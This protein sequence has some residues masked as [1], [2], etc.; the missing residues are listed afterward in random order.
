VAFQE[1][2]VYDIHRA[3]C[4][5]TLHFRNQ[6]S[7]NDWVWVQAGSEDMDGVLRGRLPAKLV[8]LFKIRDY[9]WE[10]AGRWVAAVWMLSA[11]NSGFP[12]D[13][14]GLVTGQMRE[15]ARE[16]TIVEVGTIDG[17]A[18]LIPEGERRWLVNSRIDLRTFNE[19][20]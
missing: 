17:L 20:Y 2:D 19:V 15:D 1:S 4:T 14:H 6:G 10:N 9:T 11:V 16:F 7:R 13:I 18:H 12:L 3:R 5:G 8:A